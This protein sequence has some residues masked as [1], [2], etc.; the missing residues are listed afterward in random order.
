M[1]TIRG[2][3]GV[4]TQSPLTLGMTVLD[5]R[6]HFV[7]EHLMHRAQFSKMASPFF[8]RSSWLRSSSPSLGMVTSKPL[9]RARSRMTYQRG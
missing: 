8:R 4:E 2:R 6:H 9:T 1:K 7:W 5:R 3:V